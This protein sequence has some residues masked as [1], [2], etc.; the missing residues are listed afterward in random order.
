M[1][2]KEEKVSYSISRTGEEGKRRTTELDVV[3]VLRS[4]DSLDVTADVERLDGV[5]E[6]VNGGVSRVVGAEDLLGLVRLVGLV[7]GGDCM[8]RELSERQKGRGPSG[9]KRRTGEDGEGRLVA[10]VAEGDAG[11]VGELECVD[12]LLADIEGDGHGEKGAVSETEGLDNAASKEIGQHL[13][14]EQRERRE[15]TR[16]S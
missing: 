12:L 13:A 7:D 9:R 1:S 10:G 2:E 14:F 4:V 5:V 11:T 6:V 16:L 8:K 15:R 3:V